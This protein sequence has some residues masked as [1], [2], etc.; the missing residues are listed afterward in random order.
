MPPDTT[1]SKAEIVIGMPSHRGMVTTPTLVSLLNLQQV[2]IKDGYNSH[3]LNVD[4]AEVSHSRNMIANFVQQHRQYTHLL[5]IDD[6][7]SFSADLI[8]ELLRSEKPIAGAIC[9]KRNINLEKLFEAAAAGSS[10]EQARAEAA[11]FVTRF[12][13]HS[14]VEVQNGWV[15]MAGI[16]MGITLISRNVLDQ[17]VEKNVAPDR[18]S[19]DQQPLAS[20]GASPFRYGFFDGI[21]D[22]ELKAMLSEDLS[23]CERWRKECGGDVWGNA[24]FEIG[25]VGQMVFTGKYIDRLRTGKI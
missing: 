16:G 7:M 12:T 18:W 11:S 22:E 17:M 2:L 8:L 24:N 15:S 1:P 20:S 5:F 13:S 25:H 4:Y 19:S 6:D 3:F 21:Y 9:P 14:R 10:Y 23:F